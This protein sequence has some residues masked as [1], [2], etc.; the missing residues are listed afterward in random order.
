MFS[1]IG[2]DSFSAGG[3]W[4]VE[5]ELYGI[6]PGAPYHGVMYGTHMV[7]SCPAACRIDCCGDQCI[8]YYQSAEYGG[9][10]PVIVGVLV[11]RTVCHLIQVLL[12]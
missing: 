6:S 7:D 3:V 9:D 10:A 4:G 2:L 8:A 1:C 5:A 12:L 11:G